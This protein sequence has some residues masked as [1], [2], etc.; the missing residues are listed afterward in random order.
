M[1]TVAQSRDFCTWRLSKVVVRAG[2]DGA[3]SGDIDYQR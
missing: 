2:L 3:V 1:P